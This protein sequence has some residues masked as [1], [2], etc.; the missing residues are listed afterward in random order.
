MR[1]AYAPRC[2]DCGRDCPYYIMT[3]EGTRATYYCKF[4]HEAPH[5]RRR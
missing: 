4:V 5:H 1:R 3:Y 2:K